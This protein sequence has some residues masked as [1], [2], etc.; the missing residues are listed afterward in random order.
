[1]KGRCCAYGQ[2]QREYITKGKLNSPTVSLYALMVLC[3]MDAMEGRKV[4]TVEIPDV[5]LQGNG[6][7]DERPG[8]IMFKGIMVDMICKI[9]PTYINTIIFSKDQNKKFLCSRL[10]KAIY[11]T[12]LGAIIFYTKLSKHLTDC[13]FVQN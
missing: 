9:D 5:F 13:G 3:V 4:I 7:Q 12:L 10:I 1:M 2:P 6:P 11:R 8:C